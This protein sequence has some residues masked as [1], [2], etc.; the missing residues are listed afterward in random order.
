MEKPRLQ[1]PSLYLWR[2]EEGGKAKRAS[3]GQMHV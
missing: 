2:R 1:G 3:E